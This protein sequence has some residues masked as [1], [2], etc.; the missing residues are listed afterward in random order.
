MKTV[1]ELLGIELPIIQAPMAG[2]QGSALA[3]AV[4]N[5]GGLGSLPCAMLSPEAL[6]NE[7]AAMTSQTSRPFNV[8]FFCHTPP[9]PDAER[10]AAWRNL[11]APYYKEF[12]IDIASVPAGPVRAPFSHD[13]ADVLT[14][15][16]PPVVSFHFGLPSPELLQRLRGWGAVILSSA[17]TV[18]EALWLEA[19]G[20]DAIIAQGLEA[21]GHR[22][23][24][25][26]RDVTEQM[27]TFA[28]VPQVAREVRVPVIAAGGIAD[29][30]GVA[31]AMALGATGVQIGTA[32]LLCQ[33]AT[34]GPVYRAALKSAG[35][36]R[37]ALTNLFS[38]GA[39]RGI[40]N[41]AMRELG[42]M[43]DLAPE[44]PLAAG[45]MAP[46]RAKAEAAGS[47]NFS[48]LFSG[49]NQTGCRE[50]PAAELTQNLAPGIA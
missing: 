46:L 12:G 22:G 3:V 32:Y 37:T 28:L 19:H 44:F 47:G 43:S 40:M 27:G 1:Q 45:A 10:E 41:R 11:L 18:D 8:N 7:L 42:P 33:E 14:E 29:A 23:H 9:K 4:S 5:A 39:A 31:A 34:T 17:T 20:A 49:Q 30:R 25:L 21:G 16:K 6:R 13:M 48:P 38:G 36:R 24:F 35:A 15:F 2:V 50:V 26:S